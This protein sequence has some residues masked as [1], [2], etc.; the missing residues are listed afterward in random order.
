MRKFALLVSVL[1][2]TMSAQAKAKKAE[3]ADEVAASIARARE[4]S[5]AGALFDAAPSAATTESS[6]LK[7]M[8]GD[9]KLVATASG[10]TAPI[11]EAQPN[12]TDEQKQNGFG[13]ETEIAT[14]GQTV[15][16]NALLPA[17][18]DAK[19]E[20]ATET[21]AKKAEADIPV[22]TSKSKEAKSSSSAMSRILITLGI[23]TIALFA[24]TLGLK[25]WS[26]RKMGK[27]QHTAIKI[28][29]QHYIGPKKSLAIV[30]VAGESILVGITDHNITML[31]SLSL[32]DEEVPEVTTNNFNTA[33]NNSA[34][35]GSE[36]GDDGGINDANDLY[37]R[38]FNDIRDKVS[39]SL[40]GMKEL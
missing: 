26:K 27:A 13:T 18:T 37:L 29:T 35:E 17:A 38:G 6:D 15:T 33:L 23:L 21:I 40:R 20:S 32:L 25:R 39:K 19:A 10:V 22:L 9:S 14:D 5:A 31:K 28:L 34:V 3:A 8:L 24:T 12:G 11:S 16:S 1:A 30:Q 7:D 2:L 36:F 4:M